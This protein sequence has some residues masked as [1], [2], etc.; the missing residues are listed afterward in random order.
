MLIIREHLSLQL[1]APFMIVLMIYLS[2]YINT[3]QTKI[4]NKARIFDFVAIYIIYDSFNYTLY[5]KQMFSIE[6][7]TGKI[8]YSLSARQLSITFGNNP[9]HW[10]WR[11]V[12]GSRFVHH[13]NSLN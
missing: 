8:C 13:P 4:D 3:L 6:K 1:L 5:M 11:Q 9:L 7:T 12:Q 2:R 10:S